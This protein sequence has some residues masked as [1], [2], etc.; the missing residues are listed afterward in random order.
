M[1]NII[2][3]PNTWSTAFSPWFGRDAPDFIFTDIEGKQ[4]R[5]SNYLG[6][7]VLVVFWATWCP[8]CN[9][10]IPHL[11]ELGKMLSEDKLAILAISN[12]SPELLK[13][14]A[15]E[16]EIN[17]T[18]VSLDSSSLPA[19]FANVTSIPTT[20]FIDSNGAIKLAA[21]GLVSLEEAKAI[22]QAEQ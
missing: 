13:L 18:L 22:M 14:F 3:S 21:E 5:L 15:I 6:R 2:K 1:E 10:E 4:H 16:K 12:E 20:F 19:P 11:I 8:A 7:D 9:L 17:Y